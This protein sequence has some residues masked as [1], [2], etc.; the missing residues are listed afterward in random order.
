MAN[1]CDTAVD[2]IKMVVAHCE[3]FKSVQFFAV[4]DNACKDNTLDLVREQCPHIPELNVVWAPD[5]R[6]VVDAY[7]TGYRRALA[8]GC[9]WILEID[10]GFS[11][12]PRHVCRFFDRMN[13][14]YS[15]VFGS[16]YLPGAEYCEKPRRRYFLSKAGTLLSNALLGT[17]LTD[18]TSG[19][20]LFHRD[21]MQH[22]LNCGIR[23][24]GHFFQTEIK[25]HC[26][27]FK[28]CEVPISYRSPSKSVSLR[29]V[30]DSLKIL[31][32]M[33]AVRV[34]GKQWSTIRI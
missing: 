8:A 15:C 31:F 27:R 13:E 14:G 10:A 4:F 18:M 11:H 12:D 1:E 24:K 3:Q 29:V 5:N 34:T 6:N 33:F 20:E 9:D 21:A 26:S 22:V 19:F 23:S 25:Y 32:L 7:V 30:M 17:K 2:F 16:R 28:V